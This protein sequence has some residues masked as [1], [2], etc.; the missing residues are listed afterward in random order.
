MSSGEIVADE[1]LVLRV[2]KDKP[3]HVRPDRRH[4]TPTAFEPSSEDLKHPP[5]RVSV[6]DARM[7]LQRAIELRGGGEM[8]GFCLRVGEIHRPT[9]PRAT[10]W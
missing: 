6:W 10:P 4:P 9:T 2:L 1:V 7:K 8:R 5:V 3:V